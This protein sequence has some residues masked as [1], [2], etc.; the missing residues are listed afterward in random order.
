MAAGTVPLTDLAAR[1]DGTFVGSGTLSGDFA[2]IQFRSDGVP[3]TAFGPG[4]VFRFDG[5][6]TQSTASTPW[7]SPARTSSSSAARWLGTGDRRGTAV[8][9]L[10]VDPPDALR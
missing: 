9:R 1:P 10:L 3:D 6:S 2:A 7:T 5:G 4:G 8:A